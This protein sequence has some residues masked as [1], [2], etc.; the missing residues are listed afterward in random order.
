MP[1]SLALD[2]RVELY[3]GLLDRVPLF[4]GVEDTFVRQL[5]K[6]VTLDFYMPDEYIIRKGD[7]GK[8]M[9]F[10]QRGICHVVADDEATALF[11]LPTGSFFGE[12]AL[13]LAER[14]S[15]SVAA[16]TACDILVLHRR[17]L[18]LTLDDYPDVANLLSEFARRRLHERKVAE[19]EKEKADQLR[20]RMAALVSQSQ[21][22]GSDPQ[23]RPGRRGSLFTAGLSAALAIKGALS[24]RAS[25]DPHDSPSSLGIQQRH[26][27]RSV[28]NRLAETGRRTRDS[29][30]RS[31]AEVGNAVASTIC[32][33][34][35]GANRCGHVPFVRRFFR[36]TRVAPTGSD[37][38]RCNVGSSSEESAP[39]SAHRSRE[40]ARGHGGGRRR[41]RSHEIFGDN[42]TCSPAYPKIR[43]GS[44]R[45]SDS[46]QS[47]LDSIKSTGHHSH[48]SL[49]RRGHKTTLKEQQTPHAHS[50][51]HA[52]FSGNGRD[53]ASKTACQHHA[54]SGSDRGVADD[55][56]HASSPANKA[57]NERGG[58]PSPDHP[59]L[60]RSNTIVGRLSHR[61]HDHD[62]KSSIEAQV[63]R[64]IA[65]NS[66]DVGLSLEAFV[67]GNACG[68][69][70][71]SAFDHVADLSRDLDRGVLQGASHESLLD[72]AG[73]S[74]PSPLSRCQAV[75]CHSRRPS[76]LNEHVSRRSSTC[77]SDSS[78]DGI[79][80]MQS[81]RRW[82]NKCP[83]DDQNALAIAICG[84]RTEDD[85]TR[86]VE[87]HATPE[88]ICSGAETVP[89]TAASCSSPLFL[90]EQEVMSCQELEHDSNPTAEPPPSP[91]EI[92]PYNPGEMPAN[93]S[94][95]AGTG[96]D[97]E[98]TPVCCYLPDEDAA[99]DPTA[100]ASPRDPD[101]LVEATS[102]KTQPR[103]FSG[104]GSDGGKSA[105]G[106][107]IMH[108]KEQGS[109]SGAES[110]RSSCS[111]SKGRAARRE[112]KNSS[113]QI[114]PAFRAIA[115]D[116]V[117]GVSKPG[118]FPGRQKRK[119]SAPSV[120]LEAEVPGDA[121]GAIPAAC[122]AAA[123][124]A[125]ARS[126][127]IA[128]AAVGHSEREGMDAA[129]FI[130][131]RPWVRSV[132][133]SASEEQH[134]VD[135][136]RKSHMWD[137]D[138]CVATAFDFAGAARALAQM[139]KGQC[140]AFSLGDHERPCSP[141]LARALF[142]STLELCQHVHSTHYLL[143]LP[144]ALLVADL[145]SADF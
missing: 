45:H 19:E 88:L 35:V 1:R 12:I 62:A 115:L 142:R 30:R 77:S 33:I 91:P 139:Y 135:S 60:K 137:P 59:R 103:R 95:K 143:C 104:S 44:G 63:K 80:G 90:P 140:N 64:A 16:G 52:N 2:V 66:S 129:T 97:V 136:G 53:G 18:F 81:A 74:A 78:V 28:T 84:A 99:V 109:G 118:I 26:S 120:R 29:T 8:E 37:M 123:R 93:A 9:F 119:S 61:H 7:V 5:V 101:A 89:T 10:I 125:Q 126:D 38:P 132:P 98:H 94:A 54:S 73:Q 70:S 13:V 41:R 121:A 122:K 4:K 114:Q 43:S 86:S 111:G 46:D 20:E 113:S 31:T 87:G 72:S 110:R 141:T 65:A 56:R 145:C 128:K 36:G 75:S 76:A 124:N 106:S 117:A 131:T 102:M 112:R 83:G 17:E 55:E 15:A 82:L 27:S 68:A 69:C 48:T 134:N 107:G 71:S 39:S 100:L 105:E 116:N 79:T 34:T 21:G 130:N 3:K 22:R 138:K 127:N 96:A 24:E 32:H 92:E 85:G 49:Q 14:R 6:L 11:T 57:A 47:D 25:G 42:Q 67:V 51:M 40:D 144:R 50:H 133:V 108:E 23:P 58:P